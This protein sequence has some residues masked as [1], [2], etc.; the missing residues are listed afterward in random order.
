MKVVQVKEIDIPG[1]GKKIKEAREKDPRTL[2]DICKLVGMTTSNWYRIEKETTKLLPLET[3]EKIQ[4][5][6]G[7]DL[8]VNFNAPIAA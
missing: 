4:E 2:V 6:L 7:V 8:G 3:L 1:L 5:V